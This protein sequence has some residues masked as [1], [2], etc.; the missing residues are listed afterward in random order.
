MAAPMGNR[1]RD[2][3]AKGER[4]IGLWL[5]L[6]S[7]TAAEIVSTSGFDWVLIDMEHAPND[8]GHVLDHLRALTGG[9]AFPIVRPPWNDTVM[10][11]R[12]MDIGVK[13]F[14]IP[15]VQSAEEAK[16]AVAATRYPPAGVRGIAS[17]TRANDWG[18]TAGYFGAAAD[19]VC[20]LIQVETRTALAEIEA[21]A[22]V[23]GVDGLFIG[24]SDLSGDMGYLGQPSHPEVHKAIVEAGKRI[25]AAGKPAGFLSAR[26]EDIRLVLGAGFSFVAVGSDAVALARAADALAAKYRD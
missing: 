1:F 16:A 2:A 7:P 24:P 17:A 6:G 11:K 5:G 21:I 14:L 15:Y 13:A 4:Q 20:V 26:E 10:I 23:D 9:T 3:I 25:Q 12:L 22:A 18:R 19:D 8:V